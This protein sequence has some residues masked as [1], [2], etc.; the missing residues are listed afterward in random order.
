MVG[1]VAFGE[2]LSNESERLRVGEF[3]SAIEILNFLF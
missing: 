1:M 3:S 2:M